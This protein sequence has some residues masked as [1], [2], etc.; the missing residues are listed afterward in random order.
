MQDTRSA[1]IW[2][3]GRRTG[4][5]GA[6]VITSSWFLARG[7]DIP[8][9]PLKD[10]P[11]G[12][13]M[14]VPWRQILRTGINDGKR[15]EEDGVVANR[16][17][18]QTWSDLVN[19]KRVPLDELIEYFEIENL[20]KSMEWSF[21]LPEF[22]Y[23]VNATSEK[24]AIPVSLQGVGHLRVVR[25]PSTYLPE[26]DLNFEASSFNIP[27]HGDSLEELVLA[28]P[29]PA[30]NKAYRF[31]LIGKTGSQTHFNK[32]IFIQRTNLSQP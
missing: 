17:M 10:F 12:Q 22:M 9:F 7:K 32:V 28:L 20:M 13:S 3:E 25:E 15:L 24:L 4:A 8:N 27:L 5:G 30:L 2:S 14:R 19:G 26:K 6:N 18:L 31:R 11:H 29:Q 23:E 21:T 16:P 1:K